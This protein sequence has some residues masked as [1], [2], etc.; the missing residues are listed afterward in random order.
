VPSAR[1]PF[2][3]TPVYARWPFLGE[4]R[5]SRHAKGNMHNAY[6]GSSV[7]VQ[8]SGASPFLQRIV[9]SFLPH[10]PKWLVDAIS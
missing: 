10:L 7:M 3:K 2:L 5:V 8:Q 1:W 9:V 4:I 6:S